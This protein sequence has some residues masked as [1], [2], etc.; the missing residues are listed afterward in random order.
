MNDESFD[1]EIIMVNI[2]NAIKLAY[3]GVINVSF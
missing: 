2:L 1:Y 3:T